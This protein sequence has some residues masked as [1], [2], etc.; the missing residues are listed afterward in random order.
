[1]SKYSEFFLSSRSS[2]VQLETIEVSHSSFSNVYRVVRNAVNGVTVTLE[3]KTRAEFKYYP[4]R[5]TGIGLRDN[6]D[7]G[8]KVDLG[9]LGEV[10]PLEVDRISA[11]GRY[12][13]KPKVVYRTYRSDDLSAPLYGPLIL[14]IRSFN[15]NRDGASFEANAPSLNL[16]ATGELYKIDRFPMLRGF[17]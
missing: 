16:N 15:F 1:M 10:L 7:Y 4:L 8:L 17:L 12:D 14:E 13:E 2:V 9:D 6:L 3:D 11:A 5:I